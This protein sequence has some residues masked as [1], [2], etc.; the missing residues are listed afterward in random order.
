LRFA[1]IYVSGCPLLRRWWL[2][3]PGSRQSLSQRA[4]IEFWWAD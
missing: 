1:E 4:V 2:I 3:F